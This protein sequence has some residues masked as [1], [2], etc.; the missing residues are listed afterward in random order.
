METIRINISGPEKIGKTRVVHAIAGVLHDTRVLVSEAAIGRTGELLR[1]E[2]Y[3]I[4][5]EEQKPV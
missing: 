4:E 1:R 5:P 3:A 2:E